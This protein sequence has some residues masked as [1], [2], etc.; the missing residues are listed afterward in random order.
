MDAQPDKWQSHRE[1]LKNA[2]VM[3][4][5]GNNA[6]VSKDYRIAVGKYHRALL[7]LKAVGVQSAELEL[8]G[9][10]TPPLPKDMLDERDRLLCECY[11]NLAACLLAKEKEPN[12]EKVVGYCQK[13][14]DHDPK[15][16][17]AIFRMGTALHHLGNLDKAHDVL[18]S[19][20]ACQTEKQ[21]QALLR[22]IKEAQKVQ[23][24]K[25]KATYQKMFSSDSSKARTA[26]PNGYG[27]SDPIVIKSNAA[28]SA[29]CQESSD[30]GAAS[31]QGTKFIQVASANDE[32]PC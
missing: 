29:S 23:D 8:F 2:A 9:K 22:T 28:A 10:N 20:S 12:Y 16:V 32:A 11:N 18:T 6:Y 25:V 5:E 13:V 3:K 19:T 30:S 24:Q 7:Q 26:E 15:N 27:H 14:L 31:N 4:K 1:Q 21:I 17:K